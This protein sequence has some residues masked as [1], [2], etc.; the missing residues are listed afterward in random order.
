MEITGY[1]CE[2]SF[3]EDDTF[4]HSWTSFA[5]ILC[6]GVTKDILCDIGMPVL[7]GGTAYNCRLW[8]LN[9]KI[10]G[11]RPKMFM[12]ND[13]NYREMRY[14]TPWIPARSSKFAFGEL[15][16]FLL[17]PVIQK[18]TGQTTVGVAGNFEV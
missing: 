8:V 7:H 2:D 3:L 11:I 15:E 9:R 16:K 13:G 4:Y 12:A 6:S 18:I 17:P 1:G 10:I 14:F 5:E